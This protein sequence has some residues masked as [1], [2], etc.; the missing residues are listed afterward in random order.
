VGVMHLEVKIE[1]QN[2]AEKISFFL[3]KGSS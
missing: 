2:P 3:N 1:N